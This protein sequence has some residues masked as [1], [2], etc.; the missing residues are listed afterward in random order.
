VVS[1]EDSRLSV[2]DTLAAL[3]EPTRRKIVD[4][5]TRRPWRSSELAEALS[6]SRPATSRHLK[7]LRHAGLVVETSLHDDARA[8]VYRLRPES[9]L[10]LRAWLEGLTSS[11]RDD[12]SA[13]P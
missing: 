2:D 8:K 6:S 4:L 12:E 1:A 5:L 13:A 3:A 9:L 7:V 10:R 11:D